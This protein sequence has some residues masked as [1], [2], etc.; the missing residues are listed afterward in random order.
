MLGKTDMWC[1]PRYSGWSAIFVDPFA[2]LL[3]S[4][5]G[6]RT[7]TNLMVV[8]LSNAASL[9]YGWVRCLHVNDVP[10]CLIFQQC[11]NGHLMCC[12]CFNHLLAD[13]RL[14]DESATCPNCRCEI[15]KNSCS[16]NLAVEKAV[17][18][19]PSQCEF[20][21]LPLPRNSLEHHERVLCEERWGC[22]VPGKWPYCV[23][24]SCPIG[25]IVE[26][27]ERGRMQVRRG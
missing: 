20:C 21:F 19:L 9:I 5:S 6:E 4:Y 26:V 3:T 7:S 24:V 14:K 16:R 25:V 12:G 11:T 15:T 23:K 18:E 2:I 8:L 13:A 22:L 27:A 1:F 17:S 10:P